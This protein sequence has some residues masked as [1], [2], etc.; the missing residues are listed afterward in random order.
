MIPSKALHLTDYDLNRS[1]GNLYSAGEVTT[2]R[3][4]HTYVIVALFLLLF[5]LS[6][7]AQDK[8]SVE[9]TLDKQTI[10]IGD[11]V[12][13]TVKISSDTSLTVDS[14]SVGTNLGMFEI[15]DYKPRESSVKDSLRVTTES[16]E[17][18]T[19]TTGDYQIPPMTIHYR[20]RSGEMKSITSDPLPIKVN[21]LLSGEKG[22]DIRPLR[23]PKSFKREFPTWWV[24]GGAVFLLALGVFLYFY[25]RARKPIDLTGGVV[26]TRLPWE[27]ALD[28]LGKLRDSDL[29]ARGEY[30]L[31]YLSLSEIFRGYL[32]R[33]YGISALERT[34][35]EIIA[36]F[37]T[38]ALDKQ[39]EKIIHTFLDDCDLVKFAKYHPS[40]EDIEKDFSAAKD[41]VIQT[42]TL[43]YS[44]TTAPAA[45]VS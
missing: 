41:F 12:R 8:I 24:V 6:A 7:F 4:R 31:F 20:T 18:T 43:P 42:R 25:R 32:E 34:T 29:I 2:S 33:R 17:I 39:E 40:A 26:D 10:T 19:F 23:G 30:K 21:S 38:L 28:A 16:F 13:Y 1:T 22:E 5:S 45:E 44:T 36:E 15:K 9:S 3:C 14:L 11:R 35:D 27:I 37:R